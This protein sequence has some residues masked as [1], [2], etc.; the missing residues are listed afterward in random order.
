VT[1]RARNTHTSFRLR[2][3]RSWSVVA[4]TVQFLA[5]AVYSHAQYARYGLGLD[6]SIFNQAAF[7]ISHGH[8]DP[9]SSL[10]RYSF[11]RDHF[12]LMMWPIGMFYGLFPHGILLM[13]IQDAAGVGAG[14]V[15]VWWVIEILERRL[16]QGRGALTPRTAS[17]IVASTL[18]ML[19]V[20]PWLYQGSSF[21][22]HLEAVAALFLVLGF[23]DF[24][25]LRPIRAS[26]WCACVV[27]TGD[28]G[29]LYLI[30]LGI[31]VA[32]V[33]AGVRRYG[34]GALVAGIGW[35]VFTKAARFDLGDGLV[36]YSYLVTGHQGSLTP[37]EL[38]PLAVSLVA[39]PSRWW[40]TLSAR[41]VLLYQ[42]VVQTGFVGF[43]SPWTSPLMVIVFLSAAIIGPE[44]YLLSGFQTMP[45]YAIG[46]AGSV[47]VVVAIL[48]R[49]EARRQRLRR[50]IVSALGL[51]ILLQS[52]VV[53]L[54][55]VPRVPETW[56]K[57]SVRQAAVLSRIEHRTSGS[58]EVIASWG[59]MGRFSGRP[60]VYALADNRLTFPVDTRDVVFVIADTAGIAELPAVNAAQIESYL[61]TTLGARETVSG[62]G[63]HAFDWAP[64]KGIR[65]VTLP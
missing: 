33:G 24:W 55:L 56:F 6:F 46:L 41:A 54:M 11:I 32:L 2:R 4:I 7:L 15:A 18:V 23:R 60:W 17:L 53:A 16:T 61:S 12:S 57:V 43:G 40:A 19:L 42:H 52:A 51:A 45:A 5:L 35:I 20:N 39:H 27:A 29:G 28:F 3:V 1:G 37:V 47:M 10:V 48:G 34:L 14:L 22:F 49:P 50:C 59:V 30:G 21:D 8:L 26:L 62:H 44:I 13:W 38:Q 36:L 9:W 63:I 64:P 31:G 65:Q 25:H 58:S